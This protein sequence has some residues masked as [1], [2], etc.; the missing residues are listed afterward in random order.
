MQTLNPK[1]S[2][3]RRAASAHGVRE[4]DVRPH[5][6]RADVLARPSRTTRELLEV[7]GCLGEAP[8]LGGSGSEWGSRPARTQPAGEEAV[9]A[10]ACEGRV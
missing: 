4:G 9:Q 8:A 7:E 5:L 10:G 1:T 3:G 2:G 6:R